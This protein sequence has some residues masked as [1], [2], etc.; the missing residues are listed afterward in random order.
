[1]A[2]NPFG[3]DAEWWEEL[4]DEAKD[5]IKKR[6]DAA[7]AAQRLLDKEKKDNQKALDELATLKSEGRKTQVAEALKA[8]GIDPSAAELV[9][10]DLPIE[11][12]PE[13]TESKP[14]LARAQAPVAGQTPPDRTLVGATPAGAQPAGG[15]QS[16]ISEAELDKIMQTD[17]QRGIEMANKGQVEWSEATLKL[18]S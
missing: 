10:T 2:D 1:M 16:K 18:S 7:E 8:A 5:A 4:P 11:K 6:H 15:G 12:L 17:P 13:W 3:E 9:P 14:Y